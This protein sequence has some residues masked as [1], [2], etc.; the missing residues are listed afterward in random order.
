MGDCGAPARGARLYPQRVRTYFDM[1]RTLRNDL[2]NGVQDF[3]PASEAAADGLRQAASA[4]AR[5]R[6][7]RHAVGGRRLG[8]RPLASASGASDLPSFQMAIDRGPNVRPAKCLVV[9]TAPRLLRLAGT[10]SGERVVSGD[11]PRRY[12]VAAR[13]GDRCPL[14][15]RRPGFVALV[16][17]SGP[18]RHRGGVHCTGGDQLPRHARRRFQSRRRHALCREHRGHRRDHA[19]V[20]AQ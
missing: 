4:D 10:G 14:R 18:D 16:P 9:R 13:Y 6:R 3:R 17:E 19:A 12:P 15:G 1:G 7:L 5:Q 8:G 2:H 20:P 11:L